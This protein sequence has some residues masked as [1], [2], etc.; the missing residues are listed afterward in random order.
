M[1][2]QDPHGLFLLHY[3]KPVTAGRYNPAVFVPRVSPGIILLVLV[4]FS[5]ACLP[6]E[7]ATTATSEATAEL[8]PYQT[9]TPTKIPTLN[10]NIELNLPTPTPATYI[11]V[12]GDTLIG[13]ATRL[14]ISLDALKAANPGVDPRLLVPG[15]TLILPSAIGAEAAG[16]P[17]PTPVAVAIAGTKCY[18][19]AA[20][21]LW[22]FVIIENELETAVENLTAVI[23]LLSSDGR[24]LASLEATP[25]INLLES[26]RTMPLVAYLADPPQGW[27]AV[28]GQLF[29]AYSLS[30]GMD[31]Y[32]AASIQDENIV[33]SDDGLF[34][35]VTGRVEIQGGDAG[36]IWVLAV[37]YDSAG[38]IVG[39]RRWESEGATEFET[40]VYSLGPEIST[41]DLLVEARH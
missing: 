27:T 21:E 17:T 9:P 4:I 35:N 7:K 20:G 34:A 16:F 36:T 13:I 37:A 31:Y 2:V 28:R 12:K 30:E 26:G 1:E 22:C 14:G 23:Q 24:V 33:I 38:Q 39:F 19:S 15:M 29:S 41:V 5:A 3:K 18:A 11:V 32:L 8:I 10:A 25:P 6:S 40:S